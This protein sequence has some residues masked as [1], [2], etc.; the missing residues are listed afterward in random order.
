[1]VFLSWGSEK[2]LPW[3]CQCLFWKG[4][5]G[6]T[7]NVRFAVLEVAGKLLQKLKYVQVPGMGFCSSETHCSYRHKTLHFGFVWRTHISAL[8]GP[9]YV[10][11]WAQTALMRIYK[12]TLEKKKKKSF[13][14]LCCVFLQELWFSSTLRGVPLEITKLSWFSS[15]PAGIHCR[16]GAAGPCQEAMALSKVQGV[17]CRLHSPALPAQCLSGWAAGAA[18]SLPVTWI[19]EAWIQLDPAVIYN[20]NPLSSPRIAWTA[21]VAEVHIQNLHVD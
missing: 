21:V 5:T 16:G 14:V 2:D 19:Q 18:P 3:L 6:F 13:P 1:M 7:I 12:L 20:F 17:Q 4:N 8:R 9:L 11:V 15:S 10:Q